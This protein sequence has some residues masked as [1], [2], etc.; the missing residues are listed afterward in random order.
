MAI[1]RNS[2]PRSNPVPISEKY[3][4]GLDAVSRFCNRVWALHKTIWTAT[5]AI[6]RAPALGAGDNGGSEILFSF[7][8]AQ[9]QKGVSYYMEG[10]IT[11]PVLGPA[12]SRSGRHIEILLQPSQPLLHTNMALNGRRPFAASRP[13]GCGCIGA[14]LSWSGRDQCSELHTNWWSA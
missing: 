8:Q 11:R 13:R 3:N 9:S 4:F 6:S 10:A 14:Y 1:G 12:G 5:F 2:W 7:D